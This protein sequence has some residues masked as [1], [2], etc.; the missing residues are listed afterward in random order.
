VIRDMSSTSIVNVIED[1]LSETR[2]LLTI[3]V[4]EIRVYHMQY[5]NRKPYTI[6]K[7]TIII[8]F[9]VLQDVSVYF[10]SNKLKF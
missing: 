2:V 5:E 8:I 1:E 9:C 7:M 10:N 3:V 4:Y 6:S